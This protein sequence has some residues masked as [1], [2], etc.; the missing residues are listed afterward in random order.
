MSDNHEAM[1]NIEAMDNIENLFREYNDIVKQTYLDYYLEVES[2][3]FSVY[4]KNE[5]EFEK[6]LEKNVRKWEYKPSKSIGGGSPSEY[7]NSLDGLELLIDAFK[8]G[9]RICD[10][11]LPHSFINKLYSY[12]ERAVAELA[13]LAADKSLIDDEDNRIIPLMAIRVLGTWKDETHAGMLVNLL[14]DYAGKTDI[15]AEEIKNALVAIGKGCIEILVDEINAFP[16]I[17]ESLVYMVMALAEIG[18]DNRSD[19]IFQCLKNAFRKME[20]KAIGAICLGIYGDGRAI[21][22]LRGYAQKNLNTIDRMTFYEIK[23]QVEKL[24]GNMDDIIFEYYPNY[25]K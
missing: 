2:K 23:S 16:Q 13:R 17:G 8:N 1:N 19:G 9:S 14:K 6:Q 3:P 12:G 4:D 15:V 10:R 18:A 21:P 20:R 25:W 24:G 22:L 7:F 11:D 5:D